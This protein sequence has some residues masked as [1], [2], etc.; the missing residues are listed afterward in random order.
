MSS[1]KSSALIEL[2]QRK[3]AIVI[4]IA[5]L[6]KLVEKEA[7]LRDG[8]CARTLGECLMRLGDAGRIDVEFLRIVK[9]DL[10]AHVNSG[11]KRAEALRDTLFDLTDLSGDS[12]A[13]VSDTEDSTERLA[14]E[15]SDDNK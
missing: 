10:L 5:E 2:E 7:K 1:R 12:L 9:E 13:E 6:K 3:Q 11:S 4:K 15:G 14:A 8:I